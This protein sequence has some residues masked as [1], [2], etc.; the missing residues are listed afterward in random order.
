[1]ADISSIQLPSGSTY[2]IKDS[3]AREETIFRGSAAYSISSSDISAWNAKSTK[4][5]LTGTISVGNWANTATTGYMNVVQVT[6]LR[7]S[8]TPIM[9]LVAS[10]TLALAEME[11]ADYGYI[12][13][14]ETTTNGIIVY[15]TQAPTH[16]LNIQLLCVR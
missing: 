16:N 8:D 3:T 12:Y 7:S 10:S 5:V 13:K 11:I 6:G 14:A 9:D 1:M 2:D 15:A 4:V